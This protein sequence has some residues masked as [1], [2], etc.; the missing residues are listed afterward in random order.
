[1]QGLTN[2]KNNTDFRPLQVNVQRICS[3]CKQFLMQ[4][5]VS[6]RLVYSCVIGSNLIPSY[7]PLKSSLGTPRFKAVEIVTAHACIRPLTVAPT[8]EGS[9]LVDSYRIDG[10]AT[11]GVGCKQTDSPCQL[12]CTS[13][14]NQCFDDRFGHGKIIYLVNY[15]FRCFWQSWSCQQGWFIQINTGTPTGKLGG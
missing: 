4:T 9:G 2:L 8:G 3:S 6:I 5:T 14:R 13:N 15:S 1:M 7:F 10:F 11:W 12:H